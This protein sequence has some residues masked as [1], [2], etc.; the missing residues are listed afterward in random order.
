[1]LSFVLRA[2][3]A[4]VALTGPVIAT[5]ADFQVVEDLGGVPA[6]WTQGE[7]PSP[8]TPLRLRLAVHQPKAGEFEKRVIDL[9]TPGHP[10]YGQHMKR[11]DVKRFLLPERHVSQ[12]VLSWLDDAGIA[13]NAVEDDGDWINFAVP[14][15]RAEEMLNTRFYYFHSNDDESNKVIR[16]LQ[17]SAPDAVSDHV[18]MIQPT[19]R[20]GR[21]ELQRSTVLKSVVLDAFDLAKADCTSV[22]TPDCIKDLYKMDQYAAQDAQNKLGISG[23][24]EEYARYED[25][26][27]FVNQFAP[28]LGGTTFNVAEI[29]GG[30]NLQN[31][32]KDSGEASLDV[33]YAIGLSNA[34]AIYYT[35][36]GRGPLVPDLDQPDPN[37]I[38]NEPYLD[39]LHYLMSLSDED[40][41]AVL[42]TS[43]GEN[44]Q[45]LPEKYTNKACDMFSQLG[46]RG[47][48]IIFSSGDDGPGSSCQTNDGK[49]TTRFNPIFPAS[50]PFVT[51]VGGTFR[52]PEEP[53]IEQAIYFS[54]GGFS[55]RYKRPDY[56]NAAVEG[57]LDQLG[58]RWEG[59]FNP[60]GRGFPDVAALASN[61]SVMDHGKVGLLSGT[62]FV[63]P[64][65]PPNLFIHI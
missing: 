55:D 29:H 9:S 27:H 37:D 54:S 49:N 10:S 46:A 33:D 3:A 28:D 65:A 44:E 24:L 35:T 31:S 5:G 58:S 63:A 57:Y 19:T 42:T 25:F 23:Y 51:S 48:S 16:T 20:F 8:D 11:D 13:D 56:Q 17:Y 59:L 38:S 40:L 39:Q 53:E 43:Y 6:G 32:T 62:R 30:E 12:S 36:G 21:P 60:R 41:P 45:S 34:S 18:Y 2:L 50:C 22:V 15:S 52:T 14:L 64:P 4:S 26:V 1:M 47:V 7:A 61:F